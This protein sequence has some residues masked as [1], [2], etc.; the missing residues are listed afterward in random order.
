MQHVVLMQW[1]VPVEL[2]E[3]EVLVLFERCTPS[4]VVDL[5]R[6]LVLADL[7]TILSNHGNLPV[8]ERSAMDIELLELIL[9]K[10]PLYLLRTI[11]MR[12]SFRIQSAIEDS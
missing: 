1:Q 6:E 11:N 4:W 12:H 3:S 8:T 9:C 5:S 2:D 10:Q 7:L